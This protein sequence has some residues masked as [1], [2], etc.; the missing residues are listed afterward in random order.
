MNFRVLF[1]SLWMWCLEQLWLLS[2][3][4]PLIFLS[5][6]SSFLS[7][8][9]ITVLTWLV[10][11]YR[12]FFLLSFHMYAWMASSICCFSC[13]FYYYFSLFCWCCD[14]FSLWQRWRQCHEKREKASSLAILYTLSMNWMQNRAWNHFLKMYCP[15]FSKL[16]MSK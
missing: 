1:Q 14:V 12:W 10:F 9:R 2:F 8:P 7:Y 11:G 13:S 3:F 15:L 5:F 16:K 4:Y 6:D